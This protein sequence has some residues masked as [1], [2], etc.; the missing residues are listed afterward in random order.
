MCRRGSQCIRRAD[1]KASRTAKLWPVLRQVGIALR[2]RRQ[3]GLGF[4]W[5]AC[6]RHMPCRAPWPWPSSL[7]PAALSACCRHGPQT[8]S[9]S[10]WS[11]PPR[12]GRRAWR[13]LRQRHRRRRWTS[14]VRSS[15]TSPSPSPRP[16]PCKAVPLA[17]TPPLGPRTGVAGSCA[18]ISPSG[19]S[20]CGARP[21]TCLPGSRRWRAES[22][23]AATAGGS[24]HAR[25]W[26]RRTSS[27]VG[28]SAPWRPCRRP[29]AEP[30]RIPSHVALS[31]GG[32]SRCQEAKENMLRST[33]STSTRRKG[34]SSSSTTAMC[35]PL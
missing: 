5:R 30:S 11:C 35:S 14:S 9:D 17:A 27:S 3:S 10:W 7:R 1:M 20:T 22:S 28:Q 34:W 16:T 19:A 23:S 18:W 26:T 8:P 4:L 31:R 13:S 15:K 24:T 25:R 6:R 33:A 29:L 12:L 32:A 2:Q 21:R